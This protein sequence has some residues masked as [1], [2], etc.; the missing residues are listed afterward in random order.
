MAANRPGSR[1]L[2]ICC[3]NWAPPSRTSSLGII[4]MIAPTLARKGIGRITLL[5]D[6][7]VEHSNLNRQRFYIEDVGRQNKA[8]LSKK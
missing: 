2:R 1:V 6:D 5:D 4:S 3:V 8:V 7:V